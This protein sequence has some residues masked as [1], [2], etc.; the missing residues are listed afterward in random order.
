MKEL[1]IAHYAAELQ[2]DVAYRRLKSTAWGALRF[3][4][5]A[6]DDGSVVAFNVAKNYWE[7][8]NQVHDKTN[9]Y[10]VVSVPRNDFVPG[11][12]PRSEID[13]HQLICRCWKGEPIPP[14]TR[15]DHTNGNPDDNRADNLNWIDARGNATKANKHAKQFPLDFAQVV[16]DC[17][18]LNQRTS[19]LDSV[20]VTKID[21][22]MVSARALAGHG[23]G[24]PPTRLSSIFEMLFLL[25]NVKSD[26]KCGRRIDDRTIVWHDKQL[27][28][29]DKM[30]IRKSG[31]HLGNP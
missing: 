31:P 15:V 30:S 7:Q 24:R 12:K 28:F 29:P 11:D 9:G 25:A 27:P 19:I 8:L 16:I 6:G 10:W 21:G 22:T 2:H 1:A 23:K 13:V 3:P 14:K 26:E 5:Y 18:K 20:S 17:R 4:V